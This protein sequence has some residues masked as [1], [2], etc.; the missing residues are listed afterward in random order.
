MYAHW[1]GFFVYAANSYLNFV[2]EKRI[3]IGALRDEF[4]TLAVRRKYRPQQISGDVQFTKFLLEIKSEADRTFKKGNF[5]R[6]NGHSNLRFD[7]LEFCCRCLGINVG[8]YAG[9]EEFIDK[10]LIETRNFIAHGA[11]I[12]F[13]HTD[14]SDFRDK[15]IDLI[16]ITNN[17]IEN[18]VVQESYRRQSI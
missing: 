3:K 14:V 6:I 9:Y 16:R 5:E 8:S 15:V 17:E 1:E 13:E 7:V 4:W 2:T 10:K 11:S 18:I 12:K